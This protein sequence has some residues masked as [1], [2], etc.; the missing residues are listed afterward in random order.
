MSASSAPNIKLV[1]AFAEPFNN[2]VATARTCYSSRL[3]TTSDVDK[4]EKSRVQRDAIAESTYQAGHHTTLQHA[5]FQFT[6]DRVSRQL[7][8]SFLH[9]HPFYNS[10]Q[11]SQRYVTVKPEMAY[12][13]ELSSEQLK[14]YQAAIQ[15]QMGTYEELREILQGSV[16]DEYF[17]IFPARKKAI[18]KYR[19]SIRKK[20]QEVAR[21][22]LPLATFAH[23]Y[24]TVS[25]LTLHRYSKLR[26]MADVPSEARVVIDA[27]IEVVNAHDPL[28][29]S[30]LEDPLPL[31]ETLEY[32]ILTSLGEGDISSG[33]S[34]FIQE[35][36]GRMDGHYAQLA[37]AT[38][39][40]EELM[41]SSLRATL[42]LSNAALSDEQAIAWI[43]NPAKNSYLG[44][45]LNLSTHS[46]VMR[47][48][49]HPHY[50]FYKKISHTAD[51]QDQ[52]HR[53]TPAARPQL[54]RHYQAGTPDFIVPDIL[55]QHPE[56]FELFTKTM[57]RTWQAIDQLLDSGVAAEKA[58]YLLPNAFPIRFVESGD[59][60]GWHHKW[61][62]R[63]CY[64]AQDE[65]WRASLEE[66]TQVSKIHPL[67]GQQ[68][69]PPCGLRKAASQKP[70]C[71]EG[72]RYCGVPV[73]KLGRG[74]YE[75][76]I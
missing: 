27:M 64:N 35:F 57:E 53:M 24:H 75:R 54:S 18:K 2:A 6:M 47:T 49:H 8:W 52:R 40:A 30:R 4:D 15:D 48:M 74:D 69:L 5:S 38:P 1:N 25:G 31:E 60:S 17:K 14:I 44:G 28:F 32:Q 12:I 26:H 65:I 21:Y 66:V 11:V 22:V 55:R 46:K 67:I 59:L 39:G 68:L 23:L 33:A 16:E 70:F 63:L 42:G 62:T 41:A 20:T 7:I 36:D 58:L 10:E 50:S 37:A 3:I 29:F 76:L 73:W 34:E 9:A 72:D 71:P 19:G 51:S 13:P 45:A 43:L 61:T 56:G